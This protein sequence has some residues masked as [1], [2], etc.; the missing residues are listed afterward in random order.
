FQIHLGR[1]HIVVVKERWA[2]TLDMYISDVGSITGIFFGIS[3]LSFIKLLGWTYEKILVI[4]MCRMCSRDTNKGASK[5][6]KIGKLKQCE[7]SGLIEHTTEKDQVQEIKLEEII[8]I[9]NSNRIKEDDYT[10]QKGT[11]EDVKACQPIK[12][13]HKLATKEKV[14]TVDQSNL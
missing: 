2:Y 1:G 10:E 14:A 13:Y 8:V 7:T 5:T 3:Y 12:N 11:I 6:K 4:V 9:K